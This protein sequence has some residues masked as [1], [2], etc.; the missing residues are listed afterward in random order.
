MIRSTFDRSARTSLKQYQKDIY[1]STSYTLTLQKSTR[2]LTT[3]QSQVYKTL[4]ALRDTLARQYDESLRCV[5]PN[6]ILFN[7]A[8]VSPKNA[9]GVLGACNPPTR[10]IRDCLE[11]IVEAVAFG[12]G[13]GVRIMKEREV[14]LAESLKM[15]M[16]IPVS[17]LVREGGDD[18]GKHVRFDVSNDLDVNMDIESKD[19]EVVDVD[20]ETKVDI[21]EMQ[22]EINQR[23]HLD[24]KKRKLENV[25][26]VSV[27]KSS[28][29]DSESDSEVAH[30]NDEDT[31]AFEVSEEIKKR[32]DF[33]PPPMIE[34][35]KLEPM[36]IKET[37]KESPKIFILSQNIRGDNDKTVDLDDWLKNEDKIE[38]VKIKKGREVEPFDYEASKEEMNALFN[39][40]TNE[41]ESRNSRKTF[42]PFVETHDPEEKV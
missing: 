39:Q 14:G 5:M 29:F 15:N 6:H 13:E 20:K 37:L 17:V 30:G 21:D 2:P 40:K 24:S 18:V 28:F 19:D 22:V 36:L 8:L 31:L 23:V 32:L 12:V 11:R 41:K 4:H 3:T 1:T 16:R 10:I 35:P 26:Q 33:K 27:K 9:Q 38:I 34:L 42:N 25:V 7:L